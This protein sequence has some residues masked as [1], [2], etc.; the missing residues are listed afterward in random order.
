MTDFQHPLKQ[1]FMENEMLP[2]L[3]PKLEKKVVKKNFQ[4]KKNQKQKT[5]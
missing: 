4:I 1:M 3:R 5:I 2:K